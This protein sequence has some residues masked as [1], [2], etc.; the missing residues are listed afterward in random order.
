MFNEYIHSFIRSEM[1]AD[2]DDD[3]DDDVVQDGEERVLWFCS[4][5]FCS[6]IRSLHFEMEILGS[7]FDS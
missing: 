1:N 7:S 6:V 3:G 4:V 2:D 5:L